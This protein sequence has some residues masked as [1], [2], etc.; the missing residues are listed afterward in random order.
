[1]TIHTTTQNPI[2]SVAAADP[3][4]VG[5]KLRPGPI[6]RL[7]GKASRLTSEYA[8]YQMEHCEERKLAI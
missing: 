7:L 1:M 3:E 4:A 6:A 5:T 8:N 2:D